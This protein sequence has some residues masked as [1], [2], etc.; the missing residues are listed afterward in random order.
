MRLPLAIATSWPAADAHRPS[1]GSSGGRRNVILPLLPRMPSARTLTT[2][3]GLCSLSGPAT[4][5]IVALSAHPHVNVDAMKNAASRIN[6]VIVIS[7]LP[8][9]NAF[10]F[11]LR[12]SVGDR[13]PLHVARGIRTA[14][15]ER[16]D[17]ID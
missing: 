12:L 2:G 6:L 17:V 3:T 8:A 9:S 14:T 1:Q 15:G 10:G 4:G 7:V 11:V 16:L 13:L 5:T